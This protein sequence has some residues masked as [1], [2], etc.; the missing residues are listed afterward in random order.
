MNEVDKALDDIFKAL[1]KWYNAWGTWPQMDSGIP[2]LRR[3]YEKW[4]ELVKEDTP[5][6]RKCPSD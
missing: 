2:R 1:D 3:A 5:G 6:E 4:L